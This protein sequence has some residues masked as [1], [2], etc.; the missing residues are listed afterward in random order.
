[1]SVS[2]AALPSGGL[3]FPS[4]EAALGE[5]GFTPSVLTLREVFNLFDLQRR[6][7]VTVDDW[8]LLDFFQAKE[9]REAV[10]YLQTF[11]V[12]RYGNCEEAFQRMVQDKRALKKKEKARSSL[13][14]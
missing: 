2:A 13:S 6:G 14:Q 12:E 11:L 1:M 10:T 5:W 4:F 8:R 7:F 3:S 9:L